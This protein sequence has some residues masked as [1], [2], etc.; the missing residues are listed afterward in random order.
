MSTAKHKKAGPGLLGTVFDGLQNPL[1]DLAERDGFFLHRGSTVSAL[2]TE[3]EWEFQPQRQVGERLAAGDVL[4][5]VPE[6]RISHKIMVPFNEPG[7]VEL[8]WIAK[9][10]YRVDQ[11]IARVRDR[12]G[13]DRELTM[14][15]TWP[16]RQAL[17]ARLLRQRL[18]ERLFPTQRLNSTI[19]LID[20]FF[21]IARGGTA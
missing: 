11:T 17:P 18:S 15:Q 19:R 21:P 3:A 1:H 10:K 4:G 20:T 5:T 13:R 12:L 14:Q 6:R 7:E 9:G 8:L 2:S 16:V